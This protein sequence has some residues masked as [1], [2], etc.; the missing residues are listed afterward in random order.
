MI[1]N[2]NATAGFIFIILFFG[3]FLRLYDISKYDLW[4]DELASTMTF[5]SLVD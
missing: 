1:T 2:K 3:L 4:Y 5:P